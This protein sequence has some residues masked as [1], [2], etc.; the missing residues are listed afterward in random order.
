M[1]NRRT[2]YL[3]WRAT[4]SVALFVGLLS[5]PATG[6]TASIVPKP[7][8]VYAWGPSYGPTPTRLGIPDRI[9][10]ISSSS[11]TLALTDTGE[12]WAWGT[13]YDGE[14]GNG[15][16]GT[17]V[18][19]PTK[20]A[21]L[22]GVTKVFAASG[23]SLA[24][25]ADGTVFG[26]GWNADGNMGYPYATGNPP[27]I[28][29]PT[30]IAGLNNIIDIASSEITTYALR[31]DGVL[32]GLG[33][34]SAFRTATNYYGFTPIQ[35][36][37][38]VKTLGNGVN[39]SGTPGMF[40]VKNDGTVWGWGA[41]APLLSPTAVNGPYGY[42]QTPTQVPGLT[43]AVGVSFKDSV[44]LVVRADGN[45]Y[46][47]GNNQ[48]AQ[49]GNGLRGEINYTPTQ[50]PTL[51]QVRQ[52][53]VAYDHSYALKTDGSF[54]VWGGSPYSEAAYGR[55]GATISDVP[56]QGPAGAWSSIDGRNGAVFAVADLQVRVLGTNFTK[57]ISS[58]SGKCLGSAA[59]DS[60][61][62]LDCGDPNT[63]DA[64]TWTQD[65]YGSGTFRL[66]Q[67]K[68]GRDRCLFAD[69][70][71]VVVPGLSCSQ[72]VALR[73]PDG[74]TEIRQGIQISEDIKLIGDTETTGDNCISEQSDGSIGL[75]GC[76]PHSGGAWTISRSDIIG[77]ADQ[78]MPKQV[79][80]IWMVTN[81]TSTEKWNQSGCTGT[82]I[83][84]QGVVTTAG[85]CMKIGPSD[86][87]L[88][89]AIFFIPGFRIEGATADVPYGIFRQTGSAKYIYPAD[90]ILGT[91]EGLNASKDSAFFRV[92]SLSK[93][94]AQ[95]FVDHVLSGY[96]ING[97][98]N[99]HPIT[100]AGFV[101]AKFL[102]GA[103]RGAE[104]ASA[105]RNWG[106]PS[107]LY[108]ARTPITC[109]GGRDYR[110]SDVVP[111][112]SGEGASGGPL[113]VDGFVRGVNAKAASPDIGN[114]LVETNFGETQYNMY[115]S[116]P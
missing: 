39:Q 4:V 90:G 22:G 65:E 85:H 88:Y 93:R 75:P 42:V 50:I 116:L 73:R 45:V 70:L 21:G 59:D 36:M 62:L 51:T 71:K 12:V 13:N 103:P 64:A 108:K 1:F 25:K 66:R 3:A 106:F 33:H 46:S 74:L 76:Y 2:N 97:D 58:V 15:T 43:D 34:S 81:P 89:A 98:L 31:N 100:S 110:G 52:V 54:F 114:A 109:A 47:W 96:T 87:N 37:T 19:S 10:Q 95:I 60:I 77:D 32:L 55:I 83:D 57:I 82:I 49:L 68:N 28:L 91:S 9:T 27:N 79:G 80:K 105:Y 115:R 7:G 102:A 26:W 69:R 16:E 48:F 23:W 84:A 30:A 99:P 8:D 72:L 61:V 17:T 18:S 63:I 78:V 111:C 40:V 107:N 104:F 38:D 35:V 6:Q 101:P 41:A 92:R 113:I 24:L 44:V 53:V 11:H 94:D 20:V 14:L 112:R 56:V 86:T 5:S 29:V 67:R